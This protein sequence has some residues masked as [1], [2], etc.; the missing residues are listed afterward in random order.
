V[1]SPDPPVV[2]ARF[3]RAT[4]R[5]RVCGAGESFRPADAGR[6]DC[7]H[8]AGNDDGGSRGSAC[9][10]AAVGRCRSHTTACHPGESRD[11]SWDAATA[12]RCVGAHRSFGAGWCVQGWAPAFAGV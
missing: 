8:E 11:P 10:Q 12:A 4:Q 6:L 3:M 5:R 2:I 9:I 7:P 1:S